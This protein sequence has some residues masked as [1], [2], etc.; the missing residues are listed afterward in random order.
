MGS[1]LSALA[2]FLDIKQR[3]GEWFVRLDDLDPP[4]QDPAADAQIIASLNVHGLIGN[5]DHSPA[6]D[7]QSDHQIRYEAALQL[8]LI[9]I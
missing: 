6:I 4:R 2:S 5:R 8:S 7:Y 3:G 1:L 9:H